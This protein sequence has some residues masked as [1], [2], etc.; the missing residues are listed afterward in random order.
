MVQKKKDKVKQKVEKFQ[1]LNR[2]LSWLSFNARV[3]QEAMDTRVPLIE[4]VRFLGIFSNNMDEFFRVRV[5]TLRRMLV[6]DQKSQK[7]LGFDPQKTLNK[8]LKTVVEQ[9]KDFER[10]FQIIIKELEDK[11]IYHLNETQLSEMQGIFVRE[12]FRDTVRQTLVPVMLDKK[13][14]MP[15]LKDKEIYL[16]IKLG[17]KKQPEKFQYALI[18]IPSQVVSR[19][20]VLPT[21]EKS[22]TCIILLDDVIRYC[23]KEIFSI[24]DY[25]VY[26]AYTIKLTR[27]QELDIDDDISQSFV[28]KM[29]KSIKRRKQ[30]EPV[31]FIYDADIPKDLLNFIL[32]KLKIEQSDNI[33][34][35]GRY[36]NFKDFIKFPGIGPAN[37]QNEAL[38]PVEHPD[39]VNEKSI[40]EVIKKKDVLLS[41]PYQ[42]FD[43][44]IELLREAAI[45][46]KVVSIQI[47]LYRVGSKSRIINALINAAKNG[48]QVSAIVELQ[49]RFDEENNIKL[50]RKLQD[51]GVKVIFGVPGLKVHSKL[52]LIKRR[53]KK[54]SEQLF[55][56]VGTGNFHETNAKI[57]TD[58]SLLTADDRITY[59]VEK[60]FEFFRKNYERANFKNLIVSP[61][62]ARN[63]LIDL[64][65]EEI[66]NARKGLPAY[67]TLKLNNLV[68]EEMIRK[69]YQA[70]QSG[71][72]IK[73]IIRGV[74][75]LIP[76]V[77]GMSENIEAISI[78]DRF[79]EHA[80]VMV[81]CAN[82]KNL[83]FI[84]SADWMVRNL[85]GRIEVGTPIFNEEIKKFLIQILEIQLNGT[86][87]ARI[88]DKDQQNH[89]RDSE[90]KPAVRS[91]VEIYKYIR[92]LAQRKK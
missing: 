55:A 17:I 46:P 33:I 54:N 65:Q 68:D 32:R 4:R 30:G 91:Q 70:S 42:S 47:N 51:E 69:L 6:M 40:L 11:G 67:I 28:E 13:A 84:S 77:K 82:G 18:E 73:L 45:D 87:K 20:L 52:I 25:D 41:F 63:R 81:F 44:I 89:Y 71:V 7:E 72:K 14:K 53:D 48:K 56:H 66:K 83:V 49:A 24:F 16:A 61:F 59:E 19:F 60:V 23:L 3:L 2:D 39:F 58:H 8:I 10:T 26:E 22:K 64:V 21:I 78:V 85:N 79:L 37:L 43:V 34:A 75:S 12:Y 92:T 76:G 74:C 90:G 62:N 15:N 31:R 80:R 36:H 5:A 27:D 88:L 38:P 9:Q 29:Q 57:Y 86:A 50:S 35:A 1:V